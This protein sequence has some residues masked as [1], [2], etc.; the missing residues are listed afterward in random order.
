MFMFAAGASPFPRP[1][2]YGMGLSGSFAGL[3]QFLFD[4]LL[5]ISAHNILFLMF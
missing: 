5:S 3:G 1:T 2:P 4:L